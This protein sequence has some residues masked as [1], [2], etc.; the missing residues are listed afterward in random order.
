MVK[1]LGVGQEDKKSRG[2]GGVN[3][4]SCLFYLSP[5]YPAPELLFS[6]CLGLLYESIRGESYTLASGLYLLAWDE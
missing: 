6:G 5:S 4:F 3:L 1:L 2:G